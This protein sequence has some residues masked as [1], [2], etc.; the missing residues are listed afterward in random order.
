MDE[1]KKKEARVIT[2]TVKALTLPMYNYQKSIITSHYLFYYVDSETTMSMF[3]VFKAL[4]IN[5][6]N[7]LDFFF[8][9]V[10]II[11]KT[12]TLL[13]LI[14]RFSALIKKQTA[15]FIVILN[16]LNQFD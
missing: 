2:Q 4:I 16:P 5:N 15:D 11:V 7:I 13:H 1:S 9:I 12:V 3:A 6:L 14:E 10:N 8:L